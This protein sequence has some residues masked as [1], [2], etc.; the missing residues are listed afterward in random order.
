MGK[1]TNLNP[2]TQTAQAIISGMT[3]PEQGKVAVI[4]HGLTT[5]KIQ[6]LDGLVVLNAT[7]LVPPNVTYSSSLQFQ[8]TVAGPNVHV[9][10]MPGNSSSILNR[11]IRIVIDYLAT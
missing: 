10:N 1:L 3:H 9:H 11:P 6:R 5:S 4:P 8:L 7:D 2:F